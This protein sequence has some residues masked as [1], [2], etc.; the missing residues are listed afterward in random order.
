MGVGAPG[1]SVDLGAL[2]RLD[3]ALDLLVGE[4]RELPGLGRDGDGHH[5]VVAEPAGAAEVE[6]LVDGLLELDR[7][8]AA[9]RV[10][11]GQP[12]QP[13]RA[14]AHVGDLVGQHEVHGALEDGI[15]HLLA[16]VDELVEDVAGQAL[17][18]PV[19]AGHPRG[20]V[21]GAGAAPEDRRLRVLAD[22]AAQVLQEADVD[23]DVAGLVPD[24]AR[25]V[26]GE[27]PR[28]V[29][30][31]VDGAAGALHG[32]HLADQDAVGALL[33]GLAASS[34]RETASAPG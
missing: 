12:G 18:A 32:L 14:H 10:A 26:H 3:E 1:G 24:L 5:L 19:D 21:L 20:G 23:L 30:E 16:D 13:L 28:R 9:L 4:A 27:L 7:L 11:L 34:A 31:V 25:H 33:D 22:V 2:R 29:G 8:A 17:E 15:A 6:A